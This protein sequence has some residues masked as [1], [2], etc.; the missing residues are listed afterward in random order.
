MSARL[1]ALARLAAAS[2][3]LA[4]IVIGSAIG[5]SV[6]SGKSVFRTDLSD[7]ALVLYVSTAVSAVLLVVVLLWRLIR[8]A[9]RR[10]KT[11][12]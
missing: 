2:V 9:G 1:E 5:A 11:R 12:P 6:D 4:G 10:R 8:P 3:V 7:I